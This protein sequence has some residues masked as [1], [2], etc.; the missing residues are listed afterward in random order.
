LA[1]GR[2]AEVEQDAIRIQTKRFRDD[3]EDRQYKLSKLESTTPKLKAEEVVP[4][5]KTPEEP[6]VP[7]VPSGG[8]TYEPK[9][10]KKGKN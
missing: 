4:A 7:E 2:L 8:E 3:E 5:V 6:T 10:D 9:L 1:T